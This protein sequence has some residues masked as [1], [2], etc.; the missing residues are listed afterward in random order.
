MENFS[1]K[2]CIKNGMAC[3]FEIMGNYDVHGNEPFY[4]W[5]SRSQVN[6]YSSIIEKVAL[7]KKVDARLIK[8][9]MYMETTHGYYDVPLSWM[10]QNKSIL[11][12]N[13]NVDYWG[14]TF[15]TR[16]D[17]KNPETNIR[18]GAEMILRIQQNLSPGAPVEK[19]ATLYNNI[20][21][22]VV[23]EY[24]VR[25]KKI[26]DEQPWLQNDG[27]DGNKTK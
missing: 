16:E 6:I 14:N 27:G 24:G 19:V 9:I 23:N 2:G 13:I 22:T 3:G 5:S 15:G 12:M 26:Y 21:A 17:L 10:D 4:E 11:P 7:E 25:V 8:A 18:A 1:R 20:N